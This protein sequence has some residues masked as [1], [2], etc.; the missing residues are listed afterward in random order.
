VSAFT[1][2]VGNS[3]MAWLLIPGTNIT[4]FNIFCKNGYFAQNIDRNDC[5]QFFAKNCSKGIATLTEVERVCR[6]ENKKSVTC[7]FLTVFT[8]T[9]L[10]C[11]QW[12]VQP[13]HL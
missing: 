9:F 6:V 7:F 11:F 4:I 5:F 8:V 3:V 10:P 1:G 12:M 13:L 2:E